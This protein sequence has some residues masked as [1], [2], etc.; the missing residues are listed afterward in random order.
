[1][2]CCDS[3]QLWRV[4]RT[5]ILHGSYPLTSIL[6]STRWTE[7]FDR[8]IDFCPNCLEPLPDKIRDV[9]LLALVKIPTL[10]ALTVTQDVSFSAHIL[11]NIT[12]HITTFEQAHDQR[13]QVSISNSELMRTFTL[14]R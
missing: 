10:T 4:T 8:S 6:F 9:A 7:H 2:T 12:L 1:M 11:N 3:K 13:L 5:D 14:D